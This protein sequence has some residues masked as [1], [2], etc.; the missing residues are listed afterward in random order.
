MSAL[1][2]IIALLITNLV[3]YVAS[4]LSGTWFLAPL[5]F[6]EIPAQPWQVHVLKGVMF[7]AIQIICNN[8][9]KASLSALAPLKKEQR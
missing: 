7:V 8:V 9:S 4:F 5:L 2:F 3:C 1:L 6:N